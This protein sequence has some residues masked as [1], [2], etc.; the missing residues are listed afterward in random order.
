MLFRFSIDFA[1]DFIFFD[2]T[3]GNIGLQWLCI[4]GLMMEC[5]FQHIVDI[6]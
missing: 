6:T 1:D 5:N 4:I 2:E 3:S